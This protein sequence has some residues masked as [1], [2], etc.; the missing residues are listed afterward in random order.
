MFIELAEHLACPA[1]HAAQPHCIL[2]PDTIASRMVEA[3]TIA[4]PECRAEYLIEHGVVRFGTPPTEHTPHA[5]PDAA[6]IQ[7][8][9]ELSGPGGYVVLLGSAATLDGRLASLQEGVHMVSV[10]GPTDAR[11]D[12]TCLTSADM[13]PLR[14]AMARGVVVGGEY[15]HSPWLQ[16]A[17]R[18]LLRSRRLVV[19]GEVPPPSGVE[20]LASGDGMVVGVKAG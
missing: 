16:E 20:V 18:V 8:L 3:G 13:I 11:S 17:E 9:L 5:V 1:A 10:N 6:V 14:T 19:L 7:A 15:A 2:M 12:T 4:C